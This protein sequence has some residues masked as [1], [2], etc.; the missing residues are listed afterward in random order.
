MG[1]QDGSVFIWDSS[2][3]EE[4]TTLA[5]HRGI[6]RCLAYSADDRWLASGGAD[7]TIRVWSAQNA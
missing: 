1:S 7:R 5:A 6:V 2:S 4:P 3:S